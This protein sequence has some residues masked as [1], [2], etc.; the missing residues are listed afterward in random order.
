MNIQLTFGERLKD[1]RTVY[2][3]HGSQTMQQVMEATGVGKTLMSG[4]ENGEDRGTDYR[5]I[6][7]LANHYG[8]SL[9]W[10]IDGGNNPISRE[11]DIHTACKTTGLSESAVVMLQRLN[12]LSP[13][14]D[15]TP[16]IPSILSECLETAGFLQLLAAS[17]E[18]SLVRADVPEN[19]ELLSYLEI[20]KKYECI[21][22]I[23]R[24][25][26]NATDGVFM[27]ANT[28]DIAEANH[29]KAIG[30]LEAMLSHMV[31]KRITQKEEK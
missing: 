10:L 28:H 5:N 18:Y 1:A 22:G 11:A 21:E 17:K 4:L 2:N 27:V 6:R 13:T 8:V 31:R 23:D 7:T 26:R 24:E 16:H 9:D 29:A 14:Q 30:G 25:V 19:A 15:G 3:R 12:G 20:K